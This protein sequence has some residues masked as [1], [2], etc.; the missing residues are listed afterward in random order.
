VPPYK[1][2]LSGYCNGKTTLLE[3][4]RESLE[5]LFETNYHLGYIFMRNIAA[6]TAE[7]LNQVQ[8]K[9]AIV[10]ANEATT[11]W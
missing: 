11:G 9:L 8:D 6:L 2:R 3:I 1:Y 10:L 4:D 7:R 5:I